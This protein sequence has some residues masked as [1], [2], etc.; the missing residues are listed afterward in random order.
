MDNFNSNVLN[1]NVY[2]DSSTEPTIW[3]FVNWGDLRAKLK[4]SQKATG[5]KSLYL[6][7]VSTDFSWENK[8]WINYSE[9][10]SV[11]GLYEGM[12]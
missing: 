11:L 2:M 6:A 3:G 10:H 4:M 8:A 7:C 9:G 1:L 12:T 5:I